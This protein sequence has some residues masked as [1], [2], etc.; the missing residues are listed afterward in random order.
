LKLFAKTDNNLYVKYKHK[1]IETNYYSRFVA[2]YPQFVVHD[3]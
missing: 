3:D 2:P 1:A